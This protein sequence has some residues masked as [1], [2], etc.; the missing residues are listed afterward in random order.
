MVQQKS[1]LIFQTKSVPQRNLGQIENRHHPAFKGTQPLNFVIEKRLAG[2]V[3]NSGCPNI[4]VN[5]MMAVVVPKNAKGP[6]PTLM[7][8]GLSRSIRCRFERD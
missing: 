3:D 8:F 2:H 1:P 6:V 5:I 7:M 4:D